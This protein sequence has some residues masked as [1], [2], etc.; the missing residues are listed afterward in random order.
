MEQ[1]RNEELK[2]IEHYFLPYTRLF[3]RRYL[4]EEC[5]KFRQQTDKKMGD[6][7]A[8]GE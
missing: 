3:A 1:F 4:E 5:Q 6:D 7:R 8:I 2:E